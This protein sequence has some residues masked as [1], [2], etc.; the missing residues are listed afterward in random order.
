MIEIDGGI[1]TDDLA[2]ATVLTMEGYHPVMEKRGHNK[3]FWCVCD[4]DVDSD[5]EALI[6]EFLSGEYLIE[7]VRFMRELKIVRDRMYKFLGLGD[8][9][10]AT[11]IRRDSPSV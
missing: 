2:F 10:K 3:V 9:P 8:Q 5:T 1:K 7:P 4:E 6:Q 11:L